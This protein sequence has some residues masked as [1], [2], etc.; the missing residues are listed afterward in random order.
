[1]TIV[2]AVEPIQPFSP[3]PP[4]AFWIPVKAHPNYTGQISQITIPI[5]EELFGGTDGAIGILIPNNANGSLSGIR[6]CTKA[7]RL[8]RTAGLRFTTIQSTNTGVRWEHLAYTFK[9][10]P[11]TLTTSNSLSVNGNASLNG[12]PPTGRWGF[13]YHNRNTRTIVAIRPSIFS[14]IHAGVQHGTSPNTEDGDTTTILPILPIIRA[15]TITAF[16]ATTG[17]GLDEIGGMDDGCMLIGIHR[18]IKFGREITG[19]TL[20]IKINGTWYQV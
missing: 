7:N 5:L 4:G 9:R 14:Q 8:W 13:W 18:G 10:V 15:D 11:Q 2:S 1:M 17:D 12:R 3:L 16:F 19:S 20:I 6:F